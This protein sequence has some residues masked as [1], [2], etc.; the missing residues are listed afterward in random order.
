MET[1]TEQDGPAPVPAKGLGRSLRVVRPLI[2]WLILVLVLYG[3]RTHQRW[4]EGTRLNFSVSLAGRAAGFEAQATLDG[5]PVESGERLSLGSHML[6]ITHPKADRYSTNWFVW[7]GENRL[8]EIALRRSTGELAVAATPPTRRLTVVGPEWTVKLTNSPGLTSSVP[9]D[10]Y[11]IEATFARTEEQANVTVTSGQHSFARFAPKLGALSIESSHPGTRFQLTGRGGLVS[12]RGEV[13]ATI[14]ELPAGDYRLVTDYHG[15]E[16]AQTASIRAGET[17][18]V[19]IELQFGAVVLESDPAGAAVGAAGRDCG[20]TPLV[21]PELRPGNWEFVLRKTGFEPV[22]VSFFVAANQTNT[23]RTNLVSQTFAEAMRSGQRYLTGKDYDRALEAFTEAL[24]EKPGDT[25][26]TALERQARYDQVMQRAK[27]KAA[28]GNFAEALRDAQ[29]ALAVRSDSAEAKELSGDFA[30]REEVRVEA[31]EKRASESAARERKQLEAAEA[32]RQAQAKTKHL[33][34]AFN[35]LMQGIANASKF[36]ENE[37]VTTNSINGLGEVIKQA[38]SS[39]QPSFEIVRFE[40]ARPD[41]FGLEARQRVGL[42]S[43]ICLVVGAQVRE[44][45]TRILFKVLESEQPSAGNLLGGLL[46][47]A[48]APPAASQDPKVEKQRAE[49]WE[50]RI[51]E[52]IRLVTERIQDAV[53]R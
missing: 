23:V 38:L 34:D 36:K 53:E 5:Q 17:N 16:R 42:G 32:E 46:R 22:A 25:N 41:L 51:K 35:V 49:R 14:M 50:A 9:A 45:E 37:L 11:A 39:R 18:A 31:E 29:A 24:R 52:G 33:H 40:S 30:K 6:I 13:P 8:G 3:I 48:S 19:W 21:L 27:S 47:L 7:Y 10:R 1:D 4:M 26:A 43:R 44:G 15:E 20:T 2:W 12:E 28:R